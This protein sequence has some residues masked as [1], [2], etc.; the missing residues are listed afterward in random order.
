MQDKQNINTKDLDRNYLFDNIKAILIFSVVLAHY[1]RASAT[2][3]VATIGGAIYITSFSFIMQGFL[4]ISGYFSKNLEKCEKTAFRLFLFPYLVLMPIMYVIRYVIFGDASLDMTVPTMALW[5]LLTLFFYRFFLKKILMI[6]NILLVSI[7]LSLLA[8]CIPYFDET[9]SIGRTFGFLPFFLLGYFCKKIYIDKIMNIPK[10][11]TILIFI[12]L[13]GFSVY[14][15]FSQAFPLEAWYFKSSYKSNDLT[16]IEGIFI[17]FVLYVVSISWIVVLINLTPKKRTWVV[18]IGQN[19]MS[20][21]IL[22]I[23][24]RYMI[25]GL[26]IVVNQEIISY[27]LLFV[28]SVASVW[29]FSRPIVANC[30]Q[31]SMDYLYK[32]FTKTIWQFLYKPLE[33]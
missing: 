29:I 2:F 23:I 8:G 27:I 19:T 7:L 22:H 9:L 14:M 3:D 12:I 13:V 31:L 24:V 11:F 18:S 30:Y 15:S 4:F 32:F 21:Y 20:V 26:G 25:K 28:I 17:R 6:K 16:L 33:D 10:V 1:L 5:Y